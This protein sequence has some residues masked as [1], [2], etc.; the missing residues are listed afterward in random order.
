[1]VE[2]FRCQR[3]EAA[4]L[5]EN[6]QRDCQMLTELIHH[7]EEQSSVVNAVQE[8]QESIPQIAS[9]IVTPSV[10]VTNPS[11]NSKPPNLPIFSGDVPTP[12]GEAEYTQ[13]IF[14]VRSFRE[15]YTDEAIKNAVIANCRGRANAVVRA[16]G[17]HTDLNDLIEQLNQ[18]FGVGQAGDEILREFHQMIQGPKESVEDFGA[19]LECIFRTINEHS[20]G[21][22]A[23]VQLKTRFFHRINNRLRDSMCYLYDRPEASF[24]DLLLAAIR[25][26]VKSRDHHL[27][28]VKAVTVVEPD[29]ENE[30]PRIGLNDLNEQLKS[31]GQYLKSAMF[32][33]KPKS[34]QD[35]RNQS[36][37]PGSSA[38]GPFRDRPPVQ[39]YKCSGWG[40]C[41]NRKKVT[42]ANDRENSN[43]EETREGGS[44]PQREQ[45]SPP[46]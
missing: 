21:W 8:H 7:I 3:E 40:Q 11:K 18:Q 30:A 38:A 32:T 1:M 42:F 23:P 19:K 13:W 37:G 2:R 45:A 15:S 44:T 43:G 4:H 33:A 29:G 28:K 14:Q 20:P 27:T 41:P 10:Q 22:Y 12:H 31:L 9:S 17:F 39:C 46:Q 26:E 16:K 5:H 36:Q 35:P 25:A 6:V 24:E 34:S